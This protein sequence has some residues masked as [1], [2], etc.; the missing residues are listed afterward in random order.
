MSLSFFTL[1]AFIRRG[2]NSL[3]ISFLALPDLSASIM[4]SPALMPT[5]FFALLDCGKQG[6]G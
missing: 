6:G 4:I 5:S 3:R 1:L 2:L